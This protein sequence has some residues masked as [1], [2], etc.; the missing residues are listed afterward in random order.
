M[1]N[2]WHINVVGEMGLPH[3][4]TLKWHPREC[5]GGVLK[6]IGLPL[7]AGK[8]ARCKCQ[9]HACDQTAVAPPGVAASPCITDLCGGLHKCWWHGFKQHLGMQ[10]LQ[11]LPLTLPLRCTQIRL[12]IVFELVLKGLQTVGRP[13]HIRQGVQIVVREWAVGGGLHGLSCLFQPVQGR[14]T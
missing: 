8:P 1:P 9:K 7:Q 11:V 6:A 2:L 4:I 10:M 5:C 14:N 12:R 13:L 3:K